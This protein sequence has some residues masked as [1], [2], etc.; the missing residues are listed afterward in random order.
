MDKEE[1]IFRLAAARVAAGGLDETDF[2][3]IARWAV[4]AEACLTEAT[5]R[6]DL[7]VMDTIMGRR[8]RGQV[9]YAIDRRGHLPNDK[10]RAD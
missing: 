9:F 6:N 3:S 7:K 2:Q 10:K 5:G 8:D 1:R 4:K